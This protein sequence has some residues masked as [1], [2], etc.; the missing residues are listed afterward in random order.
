MLVC[1]ADVPQLIRHFFA[2]AASEHG[3]S[4]EE[5][6]RLVTEG[7]KRVGIHRKG[8][9]L[10]LAR[11]FRWRSVKDIFYHADSVLPALLGVT[12]PGDGPA[13]AAA[14]AARVGG[15]AW[16]DDDMD[17]LRKAVSPAVALPH[18]R[19]APAR[20][21]PQMHSTPLRPPHAMPPCSVTGLV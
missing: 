14:A 17:A 20:A 4:R 3:M 18:C 1:F 9:W 19:A 7:V 21:S 2:L 13:E 6:V 16:T 8:F 5:A 15:V 12:R 11:R 10:K